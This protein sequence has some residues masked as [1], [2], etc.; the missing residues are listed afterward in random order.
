MASNCY[1]V[2]VACWF[3]LETVL[4]VKRM[5]IRRLILQ[6][7]Y[8]VQ[9][10]F[11]GTCFVSK[12]QSFLSIILY[13]CVFIYFSIINSLFPFNFYD[14][15]QKF[16]STSGSRVQSLDSW[17]CNGVVDCIFIS[18]HNF[19]LFSKSIFNIFVIYV[20]NHV[21]FFVFVYFWL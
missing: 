19:L 11:Y 15:C 1:E 20:Y 18:N 6:L 5:L 16:H 10:F 21:D 14:C 7:H 2:I 17:M 12:V 3:I 4:P 13:A 8:N 9:W